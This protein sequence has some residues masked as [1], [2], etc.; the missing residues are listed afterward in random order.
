MVHQLEKTLKDGGD[1][2]PAQQKGEAEAAIAEA[3][4][5]LAG[6]DADA[7]KQASDRLTQVA[8]QVGQAMYQAEQSAGAEAAAG[9]A[10]PPHQ[11]GEKV[12]DAEFEDVSDKK[13]AS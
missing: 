8:M 7:L 12:V 11:P 1:K 13:K 10:E 5:A 6:D 4:M 3:R 2:V 9:G